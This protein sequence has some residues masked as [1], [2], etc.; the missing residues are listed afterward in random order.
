MWFSDRVFAWRA[1]GSLGL[2]PSIAKPNQNNTFFFL[3]ELL[4]QLGRINKSTGTS[5]YIHHGEVVDD[6]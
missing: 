4:Y 2:I 5:D 3:L 1:Q 6:I